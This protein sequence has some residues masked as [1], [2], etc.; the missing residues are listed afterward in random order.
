MLAVVLATAAGATAFVVGD[1]PSSVRDATWQVMA[2]P[3]PALANVSLSGV[4]CVSGSDCVAVGVADATALAEHFDGTGWSVMSSAGIAGAA[5]SSVSCPAANMCMAT[6]YDTRYPNGAAVE[7][8][9]GS[10]WQQE[11]LPLI[12]GSDVSLGDVSCAS[13]SDCMAV[14]DYYGSDSYLPLALHWSGGSWTQVGVPSEGND[15][16]IP[17]S[18]SCTAG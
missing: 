14:G 6:G 9:D 5:L 4:S 13:A 15:Y 7:L 12:Y 8:F 1:A 2:T 17:T 3:D 11:S 10:S 18:V 16:T